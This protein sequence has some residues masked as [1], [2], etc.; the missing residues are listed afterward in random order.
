MSCHLFRC[1][2]YVGEAHDTYFFQKRD[3][4]RRLDF[5]SHQNIIVTVRML[6]YGVTTNFIDE[7]LKIGE[8]TVIESKKVC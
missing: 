6:A 1:I 3:D 7:Y 2:P 4:Y 8:A 5:Y